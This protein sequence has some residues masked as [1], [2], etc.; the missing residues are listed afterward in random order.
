[1]VTALLR[2]DTK[3]I[4]VFAVTLFGINGEHRAVARFAAKKGIQHAAHV[5][6]GKKSIIAAG[7]VVT[8]DVPPCVVVGGNFAKVIKK[9]E[10][11]D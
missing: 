10:E 4:V 7:A 2:V 6:I 8:K 11:D 3:V 9:I 1:M 5:T